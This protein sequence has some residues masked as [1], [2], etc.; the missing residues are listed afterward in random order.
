MRFYTNSHQYVCGIDL[1]T[2]MMYVCILDQRGETLVHENVPTDNPE[3]FLALVEPYKADLVVACECT[4]SWYWIAD[5]C[6]AQGIEFI[7]GHALYM[8]AIHGGKVKNDKL[9]SL[10]IAKLVRGDTF[11]LAYV[12]P[13]QWRALR[14]LLRR[15]HYLV[16]IRSEILSHIQIVNYQYNLPAFNKKLDRANNRLGIEERFSDSSARMSIAVNV[17]LL[18]VLEQTIKSIEN[19]ILRHIQGLD[20]RLLFRLKTVYG[21]GDIL[22]LTLMLEVQD[23]K[24]FDS[25]QQFCSYGRLVKGQKE[26]AGKT[27]GKTNSKIGNP[28][29]RWAFAEAAI[30]FIRGSDKAKRYIDKQS[31]KHHKAKAISILAHKLARAVYHIWLREDSFDEDCFWRQLSFK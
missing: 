26:S 13:S 24:R 22:A 31:K 11:P 25:V 27:A 15:R 21:I 6:C 19:F 2:K 28:Y 17:K 23:I 5:L 8:G 18:D 30:L 1:H 20:R 10:K 12:Y 4:F 3:R 16:H 29:I 14:D 9:D 7:L